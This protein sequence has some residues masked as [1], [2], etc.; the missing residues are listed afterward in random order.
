MKDTRSEGQDA[1]AAGEVDNISAPK[2]GGTGIKAMQGDTDTPA[3]FGTFAHEA[4]GYAAEDKYGDAAD[5]ERRIGVTK[6][7]GSLAEGEID[8]AVGHA[9]I[10]Y[11]TC[12][13]RDWT[14]TE[15]RA[16]A[17]KHGQKM[18][19]YVDSPD[20]PANAKGWI[21]ATVPPDSQ[22]VRDAYAA[23]LNE[24][25]VGVKFAK[26]EDQASVMEAVDKAVKDSS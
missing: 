13:M 15:A 26:S 22:V 14:T 2:L 17:R 18:Q 8:L 9:L 3:K 5:I 21:I 12:N 7:D 6:P 24:H 23:T 25:N 10:D 20:A 16:A 1:G 11:K 19:E 4:Y